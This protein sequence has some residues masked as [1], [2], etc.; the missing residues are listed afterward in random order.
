[1]AGPAT[2]RE[3]EA[4]RDCPGCGPG[5]VVTVRAFANRVEMTCGTCRGFYVYDRLVP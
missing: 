5:Q 2:V 3:Y 4:V 1:M